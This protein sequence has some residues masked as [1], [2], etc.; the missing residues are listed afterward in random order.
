[1]QTAPA[2][3]TEVESTDSAPRWNW[4]TCVTF[5]FCFVYFGLYVLVTQMLS[6]LLLLPVI[7]VPEIGTLWPLRPIITWTASHVFRHKEALVTTGSGSGDKTFDWVETFCLLVIAIIAV[8]I[9][10][11]FDRNRPHYADLYKWFRLFMRFSLGTTMFSYG[12]IKMIPLQMPFPYLSRLIEPFGNFSPMGVL[13]ASVGASPGYEICSGCAETL[14]GILLFIPRTATLGAL[15]CLADMTQVFVLN[16]TYDV[17]VK[18]FSFQL[19]LMSLFLLAPAASRL[20]DLF[21]LNRPVAPLNQYPLFQTRRAN[22]IAL[23]AQLAVLGYQIVLSIYQDGQS[24][25]EYG[26]GAPKSALYGIW[27]VKE[28]TVDGQPHPL[29]ATDTSQWRRLV[30]QFPQAATAQTM[31]DNFLRYA[32]SIDQDHRALTLSE[33]NTKD[34]TAELNFQRPAPNQLVLDG[35]LAGHTVHM[36]LQ[37]M[38]DKKFLLL[39]RGFHWVQE[40]P[41]NR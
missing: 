32:A 11:Y 18:L 37:L 8:A 22:R 34:L 31:D 36:C 14:G 2:V 15:I 23:F 5:R 29:L 7:D 39:N 17:P 38:D 25:K 13:W 27:D 24:W 30:F 4:L 21:L 1:M 40:Y 12:F 20:V 6:A 41:F 35:T 19:I 33:A 16:M 26:G 9:W 28:L 3:T 10:S